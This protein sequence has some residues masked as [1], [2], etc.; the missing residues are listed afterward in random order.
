MHLNLRDSDC[1]KE[2]IDSLKSCS[3]FK[4]KF[5]TSYGTENR[6]I[7]GREG[8]KCKMKFTR[9]ASVKVCLLSDESID[10]MSSYLVKQVISK[11]QRSEMLE[12][13]KTECRVQ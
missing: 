13:V 6:Q 2:Y 7:L 8:D 12:I 1:T 10:F 11:E 5:K 4:C 3:Q 9:G